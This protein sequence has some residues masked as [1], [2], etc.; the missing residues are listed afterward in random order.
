MFHVDL[1]SFLKT[2]LLDNAIHYTMSF[3][4]AFYI[5]FVWFSIS[6]GLCSI[7][8]SF[9]SVALVGYEMVIANFQSALVE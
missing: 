1:K 2:G 7:K 6:G 9:M 5:Y 4:R 3:F 8:L